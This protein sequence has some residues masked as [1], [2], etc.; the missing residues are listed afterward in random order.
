MLLRKIKSEGI[1]HNS[2]FIGSSDEAAI[3]DPRRDCNIYVDVAEKNNMNI[4]YIFETHR[5]E[6]YVI[7][8]KELENITNSV[9]Y[10]GSKI[11]FKY[12][13]KVKENDKFKLG[14]LE[15][16]I[17]ETPGHT[18][19]SISILVKD[20]KVS[21]DVFMVFTGDTLFSGDVGRTDLYGEKEK[22][23][24]SE[25]LYNSV[26]EKILKLGDGVIICPAHGKGS[27]C[28]KEISDHEYSTIGYEKKTNKL[29][30]KTKEEFIE[31][32]ISEHLYVPPY[33]KK[34]EE[35]NKNGPPVLG[36]LPYLKGMDIE[37]IKGSIGK[38]IQLIDIRSP[39]SFAGGHIPGS[40]NIWKDGLPMFAGYFL[41]YSNPILII[42]DFNDNIDDALRKLIRLGYDNIK[43][44]LGKG[45]SVWTNSNEEIGKTNYWTAEELK[46]N[47]GD[48]DLFILDVRDIS[49]WTDPGHIKYANHVFVGDIKEKIGKIP[50]DKKIVVYCDSGFKT[51]IASSFLKKNDYSNV[52]NLSGG[53]LAWKKAGFDLIKK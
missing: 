7:G 47:L 52:I 2:Y 3:I 11:D 41:N 4:K 27:V 32:K 16:E 46:D 51:S 45:F 10:H 44:F 25:I 15:L 18:A 40:L 53:I 19:E 26:H 6:D 21:D 14:L 9:I 12:G 31:Y 20:K 29:L 50:R 5:N 30:K 43:G 24:L 1:A 34:M 17:I 49:N 35:Y 38:N 23:D 42:D 8:S 13:E 39:T 48:D 36:N 28:G 22:K 33:F 37:E